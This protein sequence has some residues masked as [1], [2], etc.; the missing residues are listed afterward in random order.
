MRNIVGQQ[1]SL[2]FADIMNTKK[3]LIC[4][5]ARSEI[6]DMNAQL[7]GLVVTGDCL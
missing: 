4:K 6:G 7:L 3:I 5:F 2:N 1:K